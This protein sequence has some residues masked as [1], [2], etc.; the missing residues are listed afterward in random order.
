MVSEHGVFAG[1]LT[2]KLFLHSE[3][4]VVQKRKGSFI[5]AFVLLKQRGCKDQVDRRYWG[6]NLLF[7]HARLIHEFFH[8]LESMS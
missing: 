6:P 8:V 1:L 2:V 7:Y 5:V 4:C 3:D